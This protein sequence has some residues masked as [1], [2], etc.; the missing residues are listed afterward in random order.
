MVSNQDESCKTSRWKLL[1]AQL[2]NLDC[3]HFFKEMEGKAN[4]VIIDVRTAQEFEENHIDNAINIS[5]FDEE[6]WNKVC[7]LKQYEYFFIYCKT[8][9]RSIRVCTLMKNG[10]FDAEKIFNLDGGITAL[11]DSMKRKVNSKD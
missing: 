10:G 4:T 6:L 11:T 2:N 8:G 5:Y 9:R 1:K 7:D 3:Q